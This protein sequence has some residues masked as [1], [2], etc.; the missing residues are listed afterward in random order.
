E[1]QPYLTPLPA[2]RFVSTRE[3]FRK[4][5]WDCLISFE[6][7]RYSVPYP[8]AGKSVWVRVSRGKY[9]LVLDM[10]GEVVATHELCRDK[11]RTIINKEHYEGL[12]RGAPR[13]RALLEK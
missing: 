13:T 7:N 10:R 9:L 11:G 2:G 5:S 8:Y 6:G 3:Q 1:E 12:R 4:V